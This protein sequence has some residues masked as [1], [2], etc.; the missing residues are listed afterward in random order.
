M[1]KKICWILVAAMFG[2]LNVFAQDE[3]QPVKTANHY[4]GIQAN[5]LI[6]QIFNFS[7]SS[8]AINNP[9]FLTYQVN[10]IR[11]G[12]GLNVGF[13]YTFSEID[14]GD[15]FVDRTTTNN[16]F[17]FRVGFDKKSKLTPRWIVA[18]GLDFVVDAEKNSTKTEEKTQSKSKF[19]STSKIN[20]RGFGPHFNLSYR[21]NDKILIG[22]EAN[23]YFKA[24]TEDR[25]ETSSFVSIEFDPFTGQQREVRHNNNNSTSQKFKNFQFNAPAVI[26]VIL[27]F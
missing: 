17:F 8:G 9:Y 3:T 13:G 24:S 26:F 19:E 4:I 2:Q 22:T 20:G 23:Y 27:Q 16:D 11:T 7:G 10:S 25:D 15:D 1:L 12:A 21:I 6:R 14:N 5:Q 18:W